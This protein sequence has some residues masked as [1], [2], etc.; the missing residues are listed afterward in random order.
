MKISAA[1]R[2]MSPDMNLQWFP[3]IDGKIVGGL[4]IPFC[5]FT[6]RADAIEAARIHAGLTKAVW[7]KDKLLQHGPELPMAERVRRHQHNI[8]EIRAAGCQVPTI[9]MPDTLDP[10]ERNLVR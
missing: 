6:T 8:R 1:K 7:P 10:V 2:R 5:G 3:E 4:A 9:A